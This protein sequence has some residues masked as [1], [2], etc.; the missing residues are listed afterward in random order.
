MI[1]IFIRKETPHDYKEIKEVN[2]LSFN[3]KQ[4]GELVDSLRK[5]PEFVTEL[6]LVSIHKNKIIG[7]ILFFPVT[8]NSDTSVEVT[9]SLAPMAV[10]PGF[11]NKG[12]GG[13]LIKAGLKKARE[14]GYNSVMVLGHPEYYPRFGFMKA[15][16]WKIK[17]PFSVP[18]EVMMAIELSEGSLGFGGGMI[19]FPKEYYAAI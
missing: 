17:E 15:S 10:L 4:E 12:V 3:Q 5:R 13:S 14:L 19:D 1:D 16:N 6:S 11:R 7:H 9:L 8:I 2:N 18:D